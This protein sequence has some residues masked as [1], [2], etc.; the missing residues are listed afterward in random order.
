MGSTVVLIFSVLGIYAAFLTWSLVY[1]PLTT[2]EWP[3]SQN[4]FQKPCIVA[5]VQAVVAAITG[6]IYMR[7]KCTKY[8]AKKLLRDNYRQLFLISLMQ[9]TS[10]P[11]AT[12]ALQYVDFLTYML[13]KSCKL[14]PILVVSLLVYRTQV[15]LDKRV[16]A[17]VVTLGVLI[18]NLGSRKSRTQGTDIHIGYLKGF[19]MLTLSLL[20]DGFT[21]ATQDNLLKRN[22]SEGR[23]II[24]GAHLMFGLNLCIVIWNILFLIFI[25]PDQGRSA[26]SMIA[27]DPEIMLYLFTYAICG[28]LGQIFIFFTLEQYGSLVL[29]M[30]TVTRKMFSMILSIVVYGHHVTVMQWIGIMI[31]FG[32]IS[33]E[34]MLKRRSSIKPKAE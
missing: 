34:A 4:R 30:V 18:F 7:C 27:M 1:E 5:L 15:P 21:N 11:L 6:L 17:V 32:G 26:R 28:A 3:N 19:S 33:T 2:R 9:S 16:V 22:R 12:Y 24:T 25:D 20:L 8:N 10:A 14:I 29:V 31:V 13:A 23:H